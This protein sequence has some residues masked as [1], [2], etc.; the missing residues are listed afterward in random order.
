MDPASRRRVKNPGHE[1]KAR[2]SHKEQAKKAFGHGRENPRAGFRTKGVGTG[3]PRIG[4]LEARAKPVAARAK[5]EP[6]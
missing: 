3:K 5:K 2:R 6:T 1:K 4:K